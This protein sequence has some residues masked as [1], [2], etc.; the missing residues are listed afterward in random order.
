MR[1]TVSHL[2]TDADEAE[3]AYASAMRRTRRK[4]PSIPPPTL[5]LRTTIPSVTLQ[6]DI[7]RR[8]AEE[9]RVFSAVGYKD[10]EVERVACVAHGAK[11]CETILRYRMENKDP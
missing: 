9:S 2:A 11:R 8:A 10:W 7:G 1:A 4:R 6:E 5:G 3:A